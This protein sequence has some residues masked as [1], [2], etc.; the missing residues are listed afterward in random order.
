MDLDWRRRASMV[1]N[2]GIAEYRAMKVCGLCEC[3]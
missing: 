1:V 3:W 2:G